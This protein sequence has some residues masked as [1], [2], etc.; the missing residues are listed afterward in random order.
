MIPRVSE[1]KGTELFLFLR[2]FM[3]IHCN[4]NIRKQ[5]CDLSMEDQV[6]AITKCI[7]MNKVFEINRNNFPK[8]IPTSR[9]K[10]Q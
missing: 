2:G 7:C 10:S 5:C 1:Q 6:D 3:C 8:K 9:G 4:R